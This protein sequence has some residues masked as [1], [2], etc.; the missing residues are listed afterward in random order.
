MLFR[1]PPSPDG[2]LIADYSGPG[3]EDPASLMERLEGDPGVAAQG[4]FPP[5]LVSEIFVARGNDVERLTIG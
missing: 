2:G 5:S 3:R 4:L 1:S